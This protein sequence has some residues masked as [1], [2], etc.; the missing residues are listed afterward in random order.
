MESWN[1]KFETILECYGKVMDLFCF[2]AEVIG[3]WHLKKKVLEKSWNF[4]HTISPM[5]DMAMAVFS[6]NNLVSIYK[7]TTFVHALSYMYHNVCVH[8]SGCK[9]TP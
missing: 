5:H 7:F 1:L 9:E 4:A 6:S 2:S 8:G 3:N